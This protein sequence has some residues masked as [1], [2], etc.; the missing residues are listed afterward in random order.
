M[1]YLSDIY[2][3]GTKA[4]ILARGELGTM[5]GKTANSLILQGEIF[6]PIAVIDETKAGKRTREFLSKAKRDIPKNC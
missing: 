2:P 5:A 3:K 6:E 1:K 4:V